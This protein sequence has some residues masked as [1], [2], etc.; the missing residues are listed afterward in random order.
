MEK[1]RE[2]TP[3]SSLEPQPLDTWF[4]EL[5]ACP[6]CPQRWPLKLNESHTELHC[7]CGRYAFPISPEGIPVL[8]LEEARLLDESAT[9][10]RAVPP[11]QK[12]A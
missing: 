3:Q 10:E 9:P 1:E 12:E 5:L 8:L 11:P 2:P 6:A 4:L 7:W